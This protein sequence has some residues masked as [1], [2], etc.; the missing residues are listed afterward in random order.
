MAAGAAAD[1]GHDD[2]AITVAGREFYSGAGAADDA[3]RIGVLVAMTRRLADQVMLLTARLRRGDADDGL[4]PLVMP[5][6]L[7][8]SG[9]Q[10]LL[11]AAANETE[12]V[13]GHP[14]AGLPEVIG[15][16][17]GAADVLETMTPAT[18]PGT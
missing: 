13:D 14:R 7:V 9:L 16:L 12:G 3:A 15:Q 11:T 10:G 17:R 6:L 18:P 4:S 8:A 1:A 5:S 2:T